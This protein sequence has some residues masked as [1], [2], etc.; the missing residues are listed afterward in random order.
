[1]HIVN[2]EIYS[3]DTKRVVMRH[4]GRRFPGILLQGDSLHTMCATADRIC[5][6][7]RKSLDR[8]AYKDL[9]ELRNGLWAYLDAY[10]RTLLEHNVPMPF[11]E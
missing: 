1:M 7:A 8:D 9:N 4:P 6:A 5:A 3:D 2:V 11:S 10:K